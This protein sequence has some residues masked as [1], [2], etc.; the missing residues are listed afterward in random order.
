MTRHCFNPADSICRKGCAGN[1]PCLYATGVPVRDRIEHAAPLAGDWLREKERA[2]AACAYAKRSREAL[3]AIASMKGKTLLGPDW[4]GSRQYETGAAAAFYQ[5]A[6]MA[7]AA[8]AKNP[9]PSGQLTP[10]ASC[11]P[12]GTTRTEEASEPVGLG[13][14]NA[15]DGPASSGVG[16]GDDA[17]CAALTHRQEPLGASSR[18][19]DVL[20][21]PCAEP[22]PAP[23]LDSAY[24]GA[25]PTELRFHDDGS[26]DEVVGRNVDAH[27]EQMDKGHWFLTIGDVAVWLYSKKRI[28]ASFEKRPLESEYVMGKEAVGAGP[29]FKEALARRQDEQLTVKC[30]HCDGTGWSKI[31][32]GWRCA[33]CNGSGIPRTV[34]GQEPK[35]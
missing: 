20:R 8:L 2:D 27:L 24:A 7:I 28:T 14:I 10:E 23:T 15:G 25:S 29:E 11:A 33:P 6:E 17:P 3:E 5:A 26:L 12:S 4:D 34:Q 31:N 22:D 19:G 18:I 32:P 1:A 9:N 30:P 35:T 13:P 21:D 16:K